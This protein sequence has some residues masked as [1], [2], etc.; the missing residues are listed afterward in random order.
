MTVFRLSSNKIIVVL[1]LTIM[2]YVNSLSGGF[3]WDDSD[4]IAD[5]VE[6]FENIS[7]LQSIFLKPHFAETPYYRPLLWCSFFLDYHFWGINPLGFHI[8]NLLLHLLNT[9]LVCWFILN[10]G[11]SSNIAVLTAALFATHPVQ[12][13][14]VSWIAGRNDPLMVLFF[15]LSFN[16]LFS[17]RLSPL[18]R[19]KAIRYVTAF[20]F[21]ACALLAKETA[22]IFL[23][24]L[25]LTD[26]FYKK[27]F[28]QSATRYE[29][30][31]VY[32]IYALISLGFSMIRNIIFSG[33]ST[34]LVLSSDKILSLAKTPLAVYSYY[35]K[36]LF[37][38]LNLTVSPP[39]YGSQATLSAGNL[40]PVIFIISVIAI[41]V[42]LRKVYAEGLFGMLWVIIYLLP[43]SGLIWMG[44]PILEHRLYGA[45]VGFCLLAATGCYYTWSP[46]SPMAPLYKK[47]LPMLL[48]LILISYSILTIQRNRLWKD[49]VSIWEDAVKKAPASITALNNAASSLIKI[50][51]YDLAIT[52]LNQAQ[53]LNPQ[54]EK[55]YVNLGIAHLQKK[56]YAKA[57]SAFEKA[58]Q[59][60]PRSAETFNYMGIIFKEK[61]DRCTAVSYFEKALECKPDFL[62][63]HLNLGALYTEQ[64]E[65]QK[66]LAEYLEAL[67]Y[68]PH[69]SAVHNALGLLYVDEGKFEEALKHYQAVLSRDPFNYEILNNVAILYIKLQAFE[70]ALPILKEA[71]SHNPGSPEMSL[72]LGI[73]LFN[74]GKIQ[75]AIDEYSNALTL[76]P[77]YVDAH[78]NIAAAYL[79]IPSEKNKA[80]YHFN[81]V[82]RL[83]PDY[84]NKEVIEKTLAE[85]ENSRK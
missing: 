49:D 15:L 35:F 25:M 29:K 39:L 62:I 10:L 53:K 60:N 75:E 46:A 79:L 14:A 7:N 13:E 8:T 77:A 76:N 47:M 21:F 2:V 22:I 59:L 40:V 57:L 17:G 20:I 78:F 45:S 67:H 64:G 56:D 9:A 28:V 26:F 82:L 12:T 24:L 38:P 50:K 66:A 85:L 61:G 33:L 51:K 5:N 80:I 54:K 48:A 18:P 41:A 65:K 11:F 27:R 31:A 16:L 84:K 70:K 19:G 37:F 43:V 52:Y 6:Y 58:L 55:I 74:L 73:V 23:P 81:Q 72:N 63:S 1:A 34:K 83:N 30:A 4:L 69:N 3:V 32:S 36:V 71:I 42:L 68:A 44:V